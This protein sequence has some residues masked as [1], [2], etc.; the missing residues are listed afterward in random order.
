[1]PGAADAQGRA[2]EQ[3][4]ASVVPGAGT[5][6]TA[7]GIQAAHTNNTNPVKVRLCQVLPIIINVVVALIH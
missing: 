2:L 7:T 5:T 3:G 4:S 1:M 6:A